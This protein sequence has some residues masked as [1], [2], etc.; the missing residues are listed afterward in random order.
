M[1][2][3]TENNMPNLKVQAMLVA[4]TIIT[5]YLAF[6]PSFGLPMFDKEWMMQNIETVIS[7]VAGV[8]TAILAI[9]AYFKKPGPGD[10]IK[11]V[12]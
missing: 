7:G 4:G 12:E 6:A 2:F 5:L 10:G 11:P 3:I 1:K 9:V 8:L